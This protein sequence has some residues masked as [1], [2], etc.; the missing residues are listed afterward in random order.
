MERP[1]YAFSVFRGHYEGARF[2][3]QGVGF[4]GLELGLGDSLFSAL[5]A[6]AY[7][8]SKVYLVDVAPFAHRDLSLCRGMASFLCACGFSVAEF[9]NCQTLEELLGACSAHY[10]TEGLASLRQIPSGSV[11]FVWS[12]AGL[13]HI[14]RDDFL[15]TLQELRRIQR[16]DGVGSHRVDLSD[17]LGGG[18]NNLR[19]QTPTW[20]SDFMSRS[21]FYT[22]RLRHSEML[23]LFRQAGF[24]VEVLNCE[25]WAEVPTPRHKMTAPFRDLSDEELSI[26]GFDVVL[27]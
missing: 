23:Q 4:V 15:A 21:G 22:N 8:A 26:S 16:A 14:R 24:K 1:E 12:Q 20:E 27:H 7:G 5:I 18:L 13:E 6:K 25:R 19:F 9:E 11:D 3:G 2:A 17:R 10:L